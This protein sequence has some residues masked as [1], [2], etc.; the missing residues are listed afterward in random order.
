MEKKNIVISFK[1]HNVWPY[2]DIS[3]FHI[4]GENKK[5]YIRHL[6]IFASNI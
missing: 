2:I 3:L 4:N 5:N 6:F 1:N